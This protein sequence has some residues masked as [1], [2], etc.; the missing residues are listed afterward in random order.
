MAKDQDRSSDSWRLL[1]NWLWP[2][3][4]A[5]IGSALAMLAVAGATVG[6]GHTLKTMVDNGI[7]PNDMASAH[8]SLLGLLLASLV[9]ALASF[10]RIYLMGR[11]GEQ[12]A[13]ALRSRL[14]T[15]FLNSQAA[16][17]TSASAGDWLSRL[18]SDV[19]EVQTGCTQNLPFALRHVLVLAVSGGMLLLTSLQLTLL[20]ACLLPILFLPLVLLGRPLKRL[21]RQAQDQLGRL[22]GLA[23]ESLFA[24]RML[25]AYD[26]TAAVV[27]HFDDLQRLRQQ[28][29]NR[30]VLYRALLVLVV[31]ALVA[32]LIV[33]V[34]WLGTQQVSAQTL[35]NGDLTA[36][37]FYALM[38]AGA[39]AGLGECYS[40]LGKITGSIERIAAHLGAPA[41]PPADTGSDGLSIAANVAIPGTVANAPS[42]AEA[43]HFNP[44]SPPPIRFDQVDFRYEQRPALV[45]NNLSFTIAPGSTLAIVG[46]SGAGKTTLAML[47][48]GFYQPSAGR[49]WIGN[50]RLQD[51]PLANLRRLITWLPQEPPIL[52]G[53]VRDNLLLVA[54]NAS[55]LELDQ[56]ASIAGLDFIAQLPEGFDTQLG[57]KGMQLSAGQRQRLAI[58]RAVLRRSPIL[59]MDEPGSALDA[60]NDA[61]VQLAL[62]HNLPGCTMITIS[63]NLKHAEAAD[64]VMILQGGRIVGLGTP[65]ELAACN[66]AYQQLLA[67]SQED[68]HSP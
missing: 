39:A 67:A 38:L 13:I 30:M 53:S 2:L 63:H 36:F 24:I 42:S 14:M 33:G 18:S 20:V 15:G 45:L 50:Q 4:A 8:R 23:E 34:L 40:E 46:Q 6:I 7:H 65:T 61:A 35:T 48:L 12:L 21:S 11:A 60:V 44:I 28:L 1:I 27:R 37:I 66:L 5:W 32:A 64:Q 26:C 49:I 31:M 47:L 3:R 22:Q 58:A 59:L 57:S 68:F 52:S 54:P 9:M 25:Q 29:I 41:Q 17:Q 43:D 51:W 62:R 10:S 55:Q 16:D 19:A 56:A